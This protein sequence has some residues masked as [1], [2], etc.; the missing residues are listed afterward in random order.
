MEEEGYSGM[1]LLIKY[2]SD[3]TLSADTKEARAIQIKAR[4]LQHA[5]RTEIH[6]GISYQIRI[7]LASNAQG[8]MEYH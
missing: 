7:L 5:L 1:T 4:I 8:C 2:L 3:G 6:G